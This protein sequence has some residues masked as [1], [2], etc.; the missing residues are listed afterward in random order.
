MNLPMKTQSQFDRDEQKRTIIKILYF[1]KLIDIDEVKNRYMAMGYSRTGANRAA[2]YIYE[3]RKT[4]NYRN[5]FWKEISADLVER[6][7]KEFNKNN[8][9]K[10][11]SYSPFEDTMEYHKSIG[12]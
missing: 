12:G 11:K 10:N 2:E 4:L 9:S 8:K 6:T 3:N 5:H 7:I 1:K